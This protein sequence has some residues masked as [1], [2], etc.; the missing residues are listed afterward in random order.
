MRRFVA[1][2]DCNTSN[3]PEE[4]RSDF[5]PLIFN[6][7]YNK[8]SLIQET[9]EISLQNNPDIRALPPICELAWLPT[10]KEALRHTATGII[11]HEDY[12]ILT[13]FQKCHLVTLSLVLVRVVT[14]CNG[15]AKQVIGEKNLSYWIAAVS[16][17][18]QYEQKMW[19]G[20]PT[21]VW[22]LSTT[23]DLFFIPI[24]FIASRVPYCEVDVNF[25]R[26]IGTEKV[27]VVSP[28]SDCL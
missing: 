20:Y 6:C 22:A 27:M 16:F 25:G 1:G 23:P 13:L 17:Y 14:S 28:L 10:E 9:L 3:W 4:Y 12:V 15:Q 26:F 24:N 8:G 2:L 19:F 7:P 5:S 11:G 18:F 21:E